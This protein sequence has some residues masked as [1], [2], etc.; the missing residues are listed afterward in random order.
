[1]QNLKIWI[2]DNGWRGCIIVIA[3]TELQAKELMKKE[4]NYMEGNPIQDYEI[5][6]GF[7]FANLGD[8]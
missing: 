1:M 3:E 5:K 2:Q 4:L 6:N 7:A 8:S